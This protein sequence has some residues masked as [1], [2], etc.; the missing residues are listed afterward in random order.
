MVFFTRTAC[1]IYK[2]SVAEGSSNSTQLMDCGRRW[3][4]LKAVSLLLT[5][6]L[7]H[8]CGQLLI[9]AMCLTIAL[10][11]PVFIT[12]LLTDA[13]NATAVVEG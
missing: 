5:L 3:I 11:A 7:L 1:F 2:E 10:L 9:P 12:C 13:T 4:W 8:F 6:D